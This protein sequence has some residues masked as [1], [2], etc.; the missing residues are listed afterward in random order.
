MYDDFIKDCWAE[1][2]GRSL[3]ETA[4][5]L[6]GLPAKLGG[7]GVQFAST[8]KNAA[9]FA[10]WSAAVETVTQDVGCAAVADGL[11]KLPV[12]K[13]H[14]QQA[15]AGL[16]TQGLQLSDGA[17]LADALRHPSP[18]GLMTEKVQKTR[19]AALKRSLPFSQQ[20]EVSGGG[21]PGSSGF[22]T[23]PTEAV[24]SLEDTAWSTALRQ[25]LQLRRAECDEAALNQVSHTCQQKNAQG[26]LCGQPLD[27][28]GYHSST[29]QCG[30]GVLRRHGRI[31]RVVGSLVARWRHETPLYE[32]RV[33]AWDTRD[34]NGTIVERAIL[35]LQYQ[36]DDGT[37]WVDVS[38]RHAAAGDTAQL[39]AAAR[40]EGEAS[41]R[42]ER[43]KHRRY[44]G[45]RLIPFVVET[46]GRVGAEARHWLHA[47]T[48]E[49]PKDQQAKELTR[50]YK[51][52]SCALQSE[53]A[54][55]LRRCAGLHQ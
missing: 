6:L 16:A 46:G 33:P 26:V 44:P 49:W 45:D 18:Q 25:R 19:L 40:R 52:V 30:G 29:C 42:G 54:G 47:L 2:A 5:T 28:R 11:E 20:A 12:I 37:R 13:A 35:D 17:S 32:Q 27:D 31:E 1:L 21:G 3:D 34:A 53:V 36:D 50:A 4:V 38:C 23:Y 51:S 41:R 39:R 14:L 15:R 24:C 7:V 8:R 43:D 10:S 55:Q 48:R 9:L 22:L